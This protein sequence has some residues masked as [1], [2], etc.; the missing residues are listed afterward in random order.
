MKRKSQHVVHLAGG[1][2]KLTRCG[3]EGV[4]HIVG[5]AKIRYVN[6]RKCLDWYYDMRLILSA[7]RWA[8]G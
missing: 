7:K 4:V 1:V 6:C 5:P 8:N 2:E 3:A